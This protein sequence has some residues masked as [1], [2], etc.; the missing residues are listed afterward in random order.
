MWDS[1]KMDLRDVDC[2]VVTCIELVHYRIHCRTVVRAL[3]WFIIGS[4]VGLL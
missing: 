4:A 1:T 2:R 3:N